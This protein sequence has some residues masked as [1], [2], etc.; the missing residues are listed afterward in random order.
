M[1]ALFL[2]VAI[3]AVTPLVGQAAFEETLTGELEVPFNPAMLDPETS[4][5]YLVHIAE[6]LDWQQPPETLWEIDIPISID[7]A[8]YERMRVARNPDEIES[9]ESESR[10]PTGNPSAQ[11][12]VYV[13]SFRCSAR[14]HN[15][16]RSRQSGTVKAKGDGYCTYTP[17][18]NWLTPPIVWSFKMAMSKPAAQQIW[19]ATH[20]KFEQNP[21]WEQDY[22]NLG[23][24]GTQVDSG[25]CTNGT[26]QHTVDIDVFVPFPWNRRDHSTASGLS[27]CGRG[28]DHMSV[29]EQK[30][31]EMLVGL[32]NTSCENLS[33]LLLIAQEVDL[34]LP[35]SEHTMIRI[36]EAQRTLARQ[37]FGP[38]IEFD[39]SVAKRVD[40]TDIAVDREKLR[41]L[42]DRITDLESRNLALLRAVAERTGMRNPL[43]TEL[44]RQLD[45]QRRAQLEA[46]FGA[47]SPE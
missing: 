29:D 27:G 47:E 26:Y 28:G 37:T 10:V 6:L 25:Q 38:D 9:I 13:G 14:A 16:H 39:A 45:D 15:P 18:I 21:V 42:L 17:L 24:D 30:L 40:L 36:L 4:I 7:R 5:A 20:R 1:P 11:N 44:D 2:L 34:V 23:G 8:V 41:R 35:H 12:V 3:F 22:G 32:T 43:D 46:V 33:V 31:R 19:Y